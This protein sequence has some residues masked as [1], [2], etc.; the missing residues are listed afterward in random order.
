TTGLT[1]S[2]YS[3]GWA[4]NAAGLCAVGGSAG[5]GRANRAE[6][7]RGQTCLAAA[8]T[9]GHVPN[10]VLRAAFEAARGPSR[11]DRPDQAGLTGCLIARRLPRLCRWL[12][13]QW[14]ACHA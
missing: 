7:R 1:H 4:R 11:T 3:D 8:G 6:G 2:T 13:D 10:G 14:L 5:L 9:R 12:T